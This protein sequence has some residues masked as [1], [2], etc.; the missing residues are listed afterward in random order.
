MKGMREELI[1]KALSVATAWRTDVAGGGDAAARA[2]EG[3]FT[4][5]F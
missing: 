2:M 4:P 3:A 5:C 1:R